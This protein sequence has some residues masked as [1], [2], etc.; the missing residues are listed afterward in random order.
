[1]SARP[2]QGADPGERARLL[3]VD[4]NARRR[5]ALVSALR[6]SFEVHPFMEEGDL[7]RDVRAV[8]PAVVLLA[9]DPNH[10]GRALRA[11]RLLRSEPT[12]PRVALLVETLRR[13]SP[14]ELMSRTLASGLWV[15]RAP[16]DAV[17]AWAERVARGERA[18]ELRDP[19]RGLLRRL[20]GR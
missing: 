20:L 19:G 3:L 7:A 1:M 14:E 13:E 12:P 2:P 4:R 11:S 17:R 16:P 9:V 5:L 8:R 6:G 15:G 10:P 18:V